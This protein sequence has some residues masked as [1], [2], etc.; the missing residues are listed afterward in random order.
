MLEIALTV[1]VLA[2]ALFLATAFVIPKF[3]S[4]HA[5]TP[6]ERYLRAAAT[7]QAEA[8]IESVATQQA[9]A[10]APEAAADPSRDG[11]QIPSPRGFV[12]ASTRGEGITY[13]VGLAAFI[14]ALAF[15]A[16][17]ALRTTE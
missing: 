16:W 15:G 13:A 4:G 1:A 17:I 10:P 12:A 8:Y 5:V 3:E 14:A 7:Q 6:T 11:R 9:G 2:V